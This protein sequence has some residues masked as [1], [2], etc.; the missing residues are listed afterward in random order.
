MDYL[1]CKALVIGDSATG[2]TSIL[3]RYTLNE[4]DQ[5]Y[6]PTIGIDFGVKQMDPLL[7][8]PLLQDYCHSNNQSKTMVKQPPT[9]KLQVWDTASF[10]RFKSLTSSY[11][12]GANVIILVY[13]ITN[14]QSFFNI[15]SWFEDIDPKVILFLV[16][17]K[18][19]C[20]TTTTT[21]GEINPRQVSYQEG[22]ELSKRHDCCQFFETS[23]RTNENITELFELSVMTW[24]QSLV[25]ERQ[26]ERVNLIK[27]KRDEFQTIHLN[28]D[29][30]NMTGQKSVLKTQGPWTFIKNKFQ[31]Q[32][33]KPKS[34]TDD[35]DDRT[36]TNC[37]GSTLF[38]KP[39]KNQDNDKHLDRSRS[40]IDLRQQ[41]H[42]HQSISRK[43]LCCS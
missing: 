14:R 22:L 33:Y 25:I 38:L 34:K 43:H 20:D 30:N 9:V 27:K 2:K 19:D 18:V 39:F 35:D 23:A 11:Y 41:E 31:D 24:L 28:N 29:H 12:R 40:S 15:T 32:N 7:T 17:N 6:T 8:S 5:N 42:I 36:E 10:E 13:D 1:I 3:R 37:V 26:F 21:T 4:S 16:G